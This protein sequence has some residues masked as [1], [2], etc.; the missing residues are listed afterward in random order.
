MTKRLCVVFYFLTSSRRYL[1]SAM[2]F[3]FTAL[4]SSVLATSAWTAPLNNTTPLIHPL[5]KREPNSICHIRFGQPIISDCID[6]V[7]NLY[8]NVQPISRLPLSFTWLET[9]E[10]R[11]GFI[12]VVPRVWDQGGCRIKLVMSGEGKYAITTWGHLISAMSE[13]INECVVGDTPPPAVPDDRRGF[14]GGWAWVD[15]GPMIVVIHSDLM[16]ESPP[17]PTPVNPV[18]LQAL[19]RAG[20]IPRS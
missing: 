20:V 2:R 10:P 8:M 3:S 4:L 14:A 13:I 19:V 1:S 18:V 7:Y 15:N 9:T 12:P 17:D 6:L 11:G 16:G 5:Q